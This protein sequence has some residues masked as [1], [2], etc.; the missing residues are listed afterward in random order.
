MCEQPF[1]FDGDD[2][3]RHSADNHRHLWALEYWA[4]R[5]GWI[6]LAFRSRVAEAILAG[7]RRRLTGYAPYRA[8]GY[9]LYLYEDLAPTVS[10]V[11]ET[12][13]G[14]P[15]PCTPVFVDGPREIMARHAGRS[16]SALFA[17]AGPTLRPA[18]ILAAV[19][20][21]A[22]SIGVPTARALGLRPGDLRKLIEQMDLA[23]QV[24]ALRKRHRRRPARFRADPL[25]RDTVRMLELR[26]PPGYRP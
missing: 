21:H 8:A 11:A 2:P 26:L 17:C 7:W 5:H 6:D 16:W 15:Y 19:E 24:N 3:N 9:R 22:G 12:P 18:D 14:F 23:A 13:T 10:V 20:R 25:S 4:D 1:R